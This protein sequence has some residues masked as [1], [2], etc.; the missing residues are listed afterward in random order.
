MLIVFF[1]DNNFRVKLL[2]RFKIATFFFW[3]NFIEFN[4]V[5]CFVFLFVK[6][7]LSKVIIY[8]FNNKIKKFWIT[9]KA[10]FTPSPVTAS[11]GNGSKFHEASI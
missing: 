9:K 2:S 11:I 1:G 6:L 5:V 4:V 8:S 7:Y 3:K 10:F